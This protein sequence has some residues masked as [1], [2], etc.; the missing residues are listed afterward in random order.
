MDPPANKIQNLVREIRTACFDW[1]VLVNKSTYN[2]SSWSGHTGSN[3]RFD[4]SRKLINTKKINSRFFK[5]YFAIA[6]FYAEK[7]LAYSLS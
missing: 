2:R 3:F 4:E 6:G 1:Y 5:I 7:V